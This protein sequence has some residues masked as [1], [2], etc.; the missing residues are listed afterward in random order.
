MDDKRRELRKL[1]L[2][3][4]LGQPGPNNSS[5]TDPSSELWYNIGAS[6]DSTAESKPPRQ[7]PLHP[8][9]VG[10]DCPFLVTIPREIR[11]TIYHILL[12]G[13]RIHIR[14]INGSK[15]VQKLRGERCLEPERSL[16]LQNS[17]NCNKW[18]SR[19]QINLDLPLALLTTCHQIYEE[20]VEFLYSSNEF[21]LTHLAGRTNLLSTLR[22]LPQLLPDR[23]LT[24]IRKLRIH[25]EHMH[26]F[27]IGD[28]FWCH[29]NWISC[30]P[31]IVRL[32]G[33]H[34]LVISFEESGT[35]MSRERWLEKEG[36]ILDCVKDVSVRNNFIV[37]LPYSEGTT[38]ADV[39][40]ARCQLRLRKD[41]NDGR[42]HSV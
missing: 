32:R 41:L 15:E 26:T 22:S 39:R 13:L 38:M 1:R 4:Q 25:S 5:A 31:A 9:Y 34:D 7:Y 35:S 11:Q 8:R 36:E 16:C 27:Q 6:E 2:R 29:P 17:G 40:G 19:K 20:A 37:I 24:K 18:V 21:L 33:L 3:G 14:A 10:Q 28:S 30:W 12:G 23:H 42:W